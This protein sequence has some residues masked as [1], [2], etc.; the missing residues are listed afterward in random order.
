MGITVFVMMFITVLLAG[1]FYLW[2]TGRASAE[3]ALPSEARPACTSAYD[4][5]LG[6][7]CMS[8][9]GSAVFCGCLDDSQCTGGECGAD[10]RCR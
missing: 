2:F 5:P 3:P 10:S 1:M 9:D 4:C 7:V 6:M 8:L